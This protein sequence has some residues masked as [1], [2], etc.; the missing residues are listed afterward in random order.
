[1]LGTIIQASDMRAARWMAGFG[2]ASHPDW[3][4][5]GADRLQAE[6]GVVH[7]IEAALVRDL[8]LGPQAADQ[9]DAFLEPGG[10]FLQRH[11]EGGELDLAIAEADTEHVVAARQHI[12]RGGFFGNLHGV[13]QRQDQDVGAN[14]HALGVWCE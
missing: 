8:V 13:Q 5:T 7:L 3:R 4:A 2:S 11:V 12:E 9:G 1:M 14:L 6:G 10:S